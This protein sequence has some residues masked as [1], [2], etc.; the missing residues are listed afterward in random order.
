MKSN[1]FRILSVVFLSWAVLSTVG[2]AYYYTQYNLAELRVA[3]L[4]NKLIEVNNTLTRLS[5][6]VGRI[7]TTYNEFLSLVR[8]IM[9]RST[10]IVVVDYGNG[11]I[12]HHKVYFLEGYNNTVFNITS[13]IANLKYTYYPSMNDV[14]IEGING[15][16]N[17]QVSASSGYYWLFYVNFQLSP[18]GA[19]NT[20]V[21]DGDIIIWNYTLVSW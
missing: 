20:K 2:F 3:S 21:V 16:E 18:Y 6:E 5:E 14:F 15:V 1:I 12:E 7:N 13:A 9:S 8:L 4:T 19:L 17:I 10:A 11:T